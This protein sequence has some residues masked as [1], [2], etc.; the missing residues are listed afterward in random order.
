MNI[1]TQKGD[2]GFTTLANGQKVAKSAAQVAAY[3]AIDE[4]SAH[5]AKCRYLTDEANLEKLLTYLLHKLATCTAIAAS[6]QDSAT[7]SINDDDVFYLEKAI[8]N[9]SATFPPFK[10]IIVPGGTPLALE[11]NLARTVIRRSELLLWQARDEGAPISPI[12]LKYFNRLS[13][14]LFALTCYVSDKSGTACELWDP[15]LAAPAF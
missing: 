6:Y 8:D 14:L 2:G 12:L 7:C 15:S 4:A 10:N 13:D 9:Y 1:Y 11:L 3:G 5:L